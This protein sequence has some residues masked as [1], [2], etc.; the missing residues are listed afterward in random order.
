MSDSSTRRPASAEAVSA[1]IFAV[2][3]GVMPGESAAWSCTTEATTPPTSAR[4]SSGFELDD[5]HLEVYGVSE[6]VI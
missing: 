1:F 3:S 2:V 4:M 6:L 5:A